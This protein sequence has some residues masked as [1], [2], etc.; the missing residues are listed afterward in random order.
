MS[1]TQWIELNNID[2]VF[3]N[4]ALLL[5]NNDTISK[6]LYY[7]EED[8]LSQPSLTQDQRFSLVKQLSPECRVFN[9]SPSYL[10]TKETRAEIRMYETAIVAENAYIAEI[11]YCFDVIV[12]QRTWNLADGKRRAMVIA[13]EILK[14]LNGADI[15][16][17]GY[18]KF[19]TED[20]SQ[21]FQY[22]EINEDFLG[23]EITGYIRLSDAQ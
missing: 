14:T 10:V 18:M 21:I 3:N 5:V 19:F 1:N 6:C 13:N 11:E 2:I 23:Y 7:N 20:A 12:H 16:G 22:I 9:V 8:A 17:V 15:G 4:V